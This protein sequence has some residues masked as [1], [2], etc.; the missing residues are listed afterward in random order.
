MD[1]EGLLEGFQG[2]LP[3]FIAFPV[4]MKPNVYLSMVVKER[5]KGSLFMLYV[6]SVC[7]ARDE[8]MHKVHVKNGLCFF[9]CGSD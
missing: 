4:A 9:F 3:L 1:R 7:A 5:P 8:F 6:L 2:G